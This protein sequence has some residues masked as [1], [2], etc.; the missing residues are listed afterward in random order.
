MSAKRTAHLRRLAA[1]LLIAEQVLVSAGAALPCPA[2]AVKSSERF[3]CERCGCDCRTAEHCWRHCGC[4]TNEE[5]I[6]WA[7][8]N[9]VAVPEYVAA[10]AEH[11]RGVPAKSK[12]PRCGGRD[13]SKTETAASA[14]T[15]DNLARRGEVSSR[16]ILLRGWRSRLAGEAARATAPFA[17]ASRS[18]RA[19]AVSGES[20]PP[21]GASHAAAENGVS[22]DA[23]P[24]TPS[25]SGA[26]VDARSCG[27]SFSLRGRNA[28]C[29]G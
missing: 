27:I 5:K 16:D 11:E 14:R 3:P 29:A 9:G 22:Q 1:W 25:G 8:A 6:A 10:G 21:S 17:A 20:H 4:F 24:F 23:R 12:C 19:A 18:N 26:V 2:A 15:R 28:V 13:G 7:R